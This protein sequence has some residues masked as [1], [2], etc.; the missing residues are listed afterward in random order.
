MSKLTKK[1]ARQRRHFRVRKKIS[2]TAS[3]PRFNV[4]F[5]DKNIH[6]QFIDDE[7]QHTLAATS[8][9]SKEFRASGLKATVEGAT[10]IGKLAAEKAVAA[11]IKNVVFDRGGFRFH[12]RV[13]ALANAAREAGLVF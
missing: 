8:T 7:A 4:C 10:F 11:G 13:A 6:V 1:E 12:G 9:L 2:G 5:T 3:C